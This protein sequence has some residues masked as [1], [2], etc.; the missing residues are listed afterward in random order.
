MP[1]QTISSHNLLKSSSIGEHKNKENA[2]NC[3]QEMTEN[4]LNEGTA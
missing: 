3:C 4:W 1:N 2:R